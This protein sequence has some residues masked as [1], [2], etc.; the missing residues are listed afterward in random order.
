MDLHDHVLENAPVRC[1]DHDFIAGP[2]VP[3]SEE[4]SP[5]RVRIEVAVAPHS[6]DSSTWQME[7]EVLG[8]LLH[9]HVTLDVA[10][11]D[12]KVDRKALD[13]DTIA[14]TDRTDSRVRR[15]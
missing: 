9:D 13:L 2:R 3:E 10:F 6:G 11:L 5:T 12:R 7:R 15:L 8:C 4:H 1:G 14:L